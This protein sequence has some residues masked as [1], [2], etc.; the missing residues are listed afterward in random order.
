MVVIV[1]KTNSRKNTQK[2]VSLCYSI[3]NNI[4]SAQIDNYVSQMLDFDL[5]ISALLRTHFHS[6]A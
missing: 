2:N 4:F 6:F 1:P 5:H 3:S